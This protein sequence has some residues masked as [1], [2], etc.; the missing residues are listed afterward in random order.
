ML[1]R[2]LA[3]AVLIE[4]VFTTDADACAKFGISLRSLQNYRKLLHS[5]TELAAIFATKKVLFDRAWADDLLRA[6][7]NAAM[8]LV[9]ATT[10]AR[11]NITAQ[12]TPEMIAAVAG[13]LKLCADIHLTSKV[14]DAR[15]AQPN[16]TS[17]G[18]PEQVPAPTAEYSN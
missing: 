6:L 1:N 11:N 12:T 13:A 9:E 4:A 10:E 7:K 18:L 3:A 15:I 5:D 8:F 2:E 16:R 17:H 14:L